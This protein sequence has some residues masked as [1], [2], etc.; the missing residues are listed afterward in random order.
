MYSGALHQD[1]TGRFRRN[2][3]RFKR[4]D[5]MARRLRALERSIGAKG[6][7]RNDDD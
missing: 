5:E 6:E 3:A 4:L 1:E 7:H 2:A